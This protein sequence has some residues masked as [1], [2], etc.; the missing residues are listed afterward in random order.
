MVQAER[1]NPVDLENTIVELRG[2]LRKRSASV[3]TDN[4]TELEELKEQNLKLLAT[5][6]ALAAFN[7]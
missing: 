7:R 6:S 5:V 3:S 2:E 1:A 4:T